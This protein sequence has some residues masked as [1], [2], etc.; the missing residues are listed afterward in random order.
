MKGLCIFNYRTSKC[1]PLFLMVPH[2]GRDYGTFFKNIS[3]LTFHELRKSEDSY[4]DLLIENSDLNFNYIKSNCP[5]VYVDV[6]RS[7]LEIDSSMWK[8]CLNNSRFLR[9][10]KVESGIGVIPKVCFSG[11]KIYKD[12]LAFKIARQRLLKYYFP[13]HKKIKSTINETK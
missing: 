5:R 10:L 1:S 3:D 13:Y 4:V 12:I 11:K 8:N 7:P 6:N 2:S 9:S